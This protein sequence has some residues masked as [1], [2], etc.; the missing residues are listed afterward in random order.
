MSNP[1]FSIV[2]AAK[3]EGDSLADTVNE[4]AG[5]LAGRD[6]EIVIVDDGS[7]D[8]T[9]QVLGGLAKRYGFVRHVVHA[10]NCGKSAAILTGV[11]CARARH[12]VTMDGDGQNDPRFVLP[13]LEPLAEPGVGLVAGQRI[14]HAHS[15]LKRI[16]SKLAN[17]LRA[18]ML[19]DD[20]RDT[21][22]GLKAFPRDVFLRFPYFDTM[23]RYLPALA[24][25]E[26]MQVRHIDVTDRPRLHGKSKYGLIDRALVGLVDL[27]GARWLISRRRHVPEAREI[28]LDKP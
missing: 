19:K 26:G 21:A 18:S 11:R 20:T 22:C 5:V 2:I 7:T 9:P 8:N 4:I 3:D 16:G 14:K 15:G 24:L 23:H 1:Q 27:F 12:I 25:R 28:F 17:G 6:Y 10:Q 13:L